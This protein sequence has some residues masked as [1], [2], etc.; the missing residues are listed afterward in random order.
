MN[1]NADFFR[2]EL[3]KYKDKYRNIRKFICRDK[4]WAKGS[5]EQDEKCRGMNS[6]HER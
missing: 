5:K 2:K 3:E 4:N 6:W 1:S